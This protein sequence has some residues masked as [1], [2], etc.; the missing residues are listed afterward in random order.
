[1]QV[2]ILTEFK[3]QQLKTIGQFVENHPDGNIFQHPDMCLFIGKIKGFQ[4]IYVIVKENEELVASLL[5]QQIRPTSGIKK[6]FTQRLISFGSPIIHQNLNNRDEVFGKILIG[7]EKFLGKNPLYIQFRLFKRDEKLTPALIQLAYMPQKRYNVLIP[8]D[9]IEGCFS[10]LSI[11]K[12]RQVRKS[13]DSGAKLIQPESLAQ[14]HAF[15]QILKSLFKNKIKKPLHDVEFFEN[16]YKESQNRRLGKMFLVEYKS[17]IIGGILCPISKGKCIYEWYICGL[18]QEYNK[19]GIY[20]SVLATWGAIEFAAENGIP[21]FDLM[22]A[23]KPGIAYGVRD[24]KL[25]FGGEKVVQYRYNKII[26]KTK[27]GL[28]ELAYNIK[29]WTGL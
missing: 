10:R 23:G 21:N 16:F 12:Q 24:F 22:G 28:A 1:M 3:P 8:I 18:D 20:P 15:Y 11:S 13:L 5:L 14:V 9:T 29:Y 25:K 17:E 26:N 6:Q 27:Y 2:Q 7:L 19:K 4:S